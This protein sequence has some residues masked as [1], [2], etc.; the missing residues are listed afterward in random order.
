MK[1]KLIFG[2]SSILG[3][4]LAACNATD[5]N[6]DAA[7]IPPQ[8]DSA[9]PTTYDVGSGAIDTTPVVADPY[10]W[11][12]VQDTEQ[13]ACSTN[14]PGTDVDAVALQSA[15]GAVLGYGKVGT[16]KFT[17][18]PQGNACANAD[19][20]GGNCKY[21]YIG[22]H[23]PDPEVLVHYTEGMSNGNVAAVGDDYGYLSLNAGTLQLQIGAGDGTGAA[24]ELQSGQ[25]IYVYEI[26]QTYITSGDAYAGCICAP[27]HFTVMLQTASGK[28][29][30]P[31]TPYP[32]A[33]DNATACAAAPGGVTDGCG[34]TTFMIP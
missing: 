9:M 22:T 6:P 10:V 12:V 33:A 34:S 18:N 1:T 23:F 2:L 14:G 15:A 19:C 28:Y 8:P 21:A 24:L 3:L 5:D 4:G 7:Y 32:P 30:A 31:L 11:V 26:D 27:E 20:S 13:V 29:S 25:F 17:A 16:A